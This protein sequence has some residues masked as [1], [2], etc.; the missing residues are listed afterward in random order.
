MRR[1]TPVLVF[2]LAFVGSREPISPVKPVTPSFQIPQRDPNPPAVLQQRPG[3]LN[4]V[5]ADAILVRNRGNVALAFDFWDGDSWRRVSISSGK[6]KN[7][8]CP[9]C[10]NAIEISFHDGTEARR[11]TEPTSRAYKIYW[12]GQR[13]AIEPEP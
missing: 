11:V 12:A 5:N 13:W 10:S 3:H 6:E 9:K 4:I 2:L 8:M 1:I 7:V